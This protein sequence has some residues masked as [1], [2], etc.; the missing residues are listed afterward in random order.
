[1]PGQWKIVFDNITGTIYSNN[2]RAIS[3]NALQ[4]L[5]KNIWQ[6]KDNII[7]QT[8]RPYYVDDLCLYDSGE[9]L[10]FYI[11]KE[12]TSGIFD[13]NKWVIILAEGISDDYIILPASD[14]LIDNFDNTLI[15]RACVLNNSNKVE[16]SNRQPDT[17]GVSGEWLIEPNILPTKPTKRKV[18]FAFSAPLDT[19]GESFTLNGVIFTAREFPSS[20]TEFSVS[21]NLNSSLLLISDVLNDYWGPLNEGTLTFDFDNNLFTWEV[22]QEYAGTAGNSLAFASNT[23]KITVGNIV[24]GNDNNLQTANSFIL[25]FNIGPNQIN[26]SL[27]DILN[28]NT[29]GELLAD[30]YW[31]DDLEQFSEKLLDYL[32]NDISLSSYFSF[33]LETTAI[34]LYYNNIPTS[35]D[36]IV[37]IYTLYSFF[38]VDTIQQNVLPNSGVVEELFIGQLVNVSGENAILKTKY[39]SVFEI[40]GNYSFSNDLFSRIFVLANDGK[41]MPFSNLIFSNDNGFFTLLRNPLFVAVL[42]TNESNK[43]FFK[44]VYF[45]PFQ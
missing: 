23:P 44:E 45:L 9:G 40:E 13:P 35:Y 37:E 16:L 28:A 7:Y 29:T 4:I 3:G 42:P 2:N 6:K 22:G 41:L 27:A 8:D 21:D 24:T 12:N 43:Y 26:I 1:M 14:S 33:N 5:L 20:N 19:D 38:N 10:K 11:C 17:P 25:S 36:D 30:L 39:P 32:T 15:G 18:Q 31:P 34:R